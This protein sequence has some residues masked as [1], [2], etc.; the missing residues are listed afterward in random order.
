VIVRKQAM[1]R[2]AEDAIDQERDGGAVHDIAGGSSNN[3][4]RRRAGRARQVRARTSFIA[5]ATRAG[6]R[7]RQVGLKRRTLC[8]TGASQSMESY[9][10]NVPYRVARADVTGLLWSQVIWRGAPH[11]FMRTRPRRERQLGYR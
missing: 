4:I 9:A 2:E 5:T 6:R 7:L 8:V 3:C 1:F 10:R 11:G